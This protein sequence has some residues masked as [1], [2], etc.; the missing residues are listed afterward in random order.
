MTIALSPNG[1]NAYQE[2][3]APTRLLVGTQRGLSI[4]ERSGPGAAWRLVETVLAGS[5][6]SSAMVLP[7]GQGV[8]VGAHTGGVFFSGDDGANWERRDHGITEEHV[9]SVKFQDLPGQLTLYAGTEP[10]RLF[11][12]RD[13]GQHWEE[14]AS[15]R[16]VPNQEHW[17]FPPPPHTAHLKTMAFDRRAP[18]RY[19]V[20][21]EQGALLLTEDDG[22]TWRELDSYSKAEDDVYRDIH[23][24]VPRPSNPDELDMTSGN[25]LYYSPDAGRTFEHL[26]DTHARIGYP[27]Q[28]VFSPEDDRVLFVAGSRHAPGTWRESHQAD[29]TVLVSRDGGRTWQT[30]GQGLPAAMRAN[31]EAMSLAA[32][33]GGYSLF[34]GTTDGEVYG[35]DDRGESWSLI[36]SG[37]GAVSKGGHYR[38]LQAVAA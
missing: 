2:P 28:L 11:R 14:L 22:A 19:F 8:V 35:S 33:P 6:V 12:S 32:Y 13:L 26:L 21:V 27:D 25:G 4:L 1:V 30:A 31:I 29:A 24:V 7:H 17:T 10:V 3:V 38:N 16:S 9:F 15:L 5:H 20:G 18:S 34:A 36:A 23:Q 37:L